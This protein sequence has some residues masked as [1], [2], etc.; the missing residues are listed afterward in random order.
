MKGKLLNYIRPSLVW[1]FFGLATIII[2]YSLVHS[3]LFYYV[4][5]GDR[6]ISRSVML[7]DIFWVSGAELNHREGERV[8]GGAIHYISWLLARIHPSPFFTYTTVLTISLGSGFLLFDIAKRLDGS[9]AG[10]ATLLVF[11]TSSLVLTTILRL[12][13]PTFA[14]PFNVLAFYFLSRYVLE[15]RDGHL[16]LFLGCAVIAAQMQMSA[17]YLVFI[18]A[19]YLFIFK[20][21]MSMRAWSLGLVVMVLLYLPWLL[22][23][24]VGI[25]EQTHIVPQINHELVVGL[26][27][28]ID[29]AVIFIKKLPHHLSTTISL[30]EVRL[31]KVDLLIPVGAMIVAGLGWWTI[32]NRYSEAGERIE[33][34]GSSVQIRSYFGFL[35]FLV[36]T[37]LVLFDLSLVFI[38]GDIGRKARYYSFLAPALALMIGLGFSVMFRW[39]FERPGQWLAKLGVLALA[40]L[41]ALKGAVAIYA[42]YRRPTL[43]IGEHPQF[44]EAKGFL[45]D[46]HESFGLSSEQIKVQA[47]FVIHEKNNWRTRVM[48]LNYLINYLDFST[49]S[50]SYDGCIAV[51]ARHSDINDKYFTPDQ[52][53]DALRHL[54]FTDLILPGKTLFK[55]AVAEN[56][57]QGIRIEHVV[58]REKY[59]LLGFQ[60]SLD[61]CPKSFMNPY[62]LTPAEKSIEEA[63]TDP[64]N[65]L[66]EMTGSE[67]LRSFF[68][69]HPVPD[70]R[71]PINLRVDLA[72]TADGT[73]L[74]TLHSKQLR[75]SEA[76]L[77]GYWETRSIRRPR[78]VL[79]ATNGTEQRF[80]LYPG[81]LGSSTY[82][83]PW[84]L[85][86]VDIGFGLFHAALEFDDEAGTHR[87]N[88]T[89]KL[90]V[91]PQATKL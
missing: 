87:F 2:V 19:L 57:A 86:L 79:I 7:G 88:L 83:T 17:L 13:N 49:K 26:P 80:V 41:I 52:V 84:P 56:L 15:K 35:F 76:L 14:F 23:K 53:K 16:V 34:T 58:V 46:I 32:R 55:K 31:I 77:D 27:N 25:F 72:P 47:S 22:Q 21:P 3:D 71:F 67:G 62:I 38:G 68:I 4:I 1:L 24:A 10:S 45:E 82:Q 6:D 28:L 5:W 40:G 29:E 73:L 44:R 63:G 20:R 70:V 50:K 39:Y 64:D 78:I 90:R 75:N 85:H 37:F 36:F 89:D 11:L 8:P 91:G 30:G 9:L 42:D 81:D 66:L 61:G 54:P 33:V 60:W 59:V 48:P 43:G 18:G 69:R 12:Y 65:K 51:V 74:V